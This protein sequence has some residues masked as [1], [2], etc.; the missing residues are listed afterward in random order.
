MRHVT[1]GVRHAMPA[2]DVC[3][4]AMQATAHLN[5]VS[6]DK[7]GGLIADFLALSCDDKPRGVRKIVL[8]PFVRKTVRHEGNRYLRC[9]RA[10]LAHDEFPTFASLL[11]KFRERLQE[12]MFT[13]GARFQKDL[14]RVRCGVRVANGTTA[15][16]LHPPPAAA[17]VSSYVP[18]RNGRRRQCAW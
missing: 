12:R 7:P 10:E 9:G 16:P 2:H 11:E 3:R 18:F 13:H 4:Q 6:Y 17:T 8:G 5:R 14:R 1:D 15:T